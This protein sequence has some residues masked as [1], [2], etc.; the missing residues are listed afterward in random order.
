MS[1]DVWCVQYLTYEEIDALPEPKR[2]RAIDGHDREL[3]ARKL[4]FLDA[5]ALV[6]KLGFGHSMHPSR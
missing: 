5:K 2:T 4:P 3:V 1:W 6:E